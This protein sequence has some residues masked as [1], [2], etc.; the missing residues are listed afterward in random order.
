MTLFKVF[1][2]SFPVDTTEPG[3]VRFAS[4]VR[5]DCRSGN[6]SLRGESHGT[7]QVVDAGTAVFIKLLQLTSL[8]CNL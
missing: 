2:S 6:R 5:N 4:A 7:A 1:G 3:T 8:P